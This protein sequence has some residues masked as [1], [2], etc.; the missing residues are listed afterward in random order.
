MR[1][2]LLAGV[3]VLAV[4]APPAEATFH[5]MKVREVHTGGASG[6]SYVEL[7]MWTGGQNE[8]G[9]HPIVVYAANGSPQHTFNLP[10]DVPNGQSQRTVLIAG[11][12]YA[13]TF[14]SGPSA[15]ATDSEL[16][17][18][19]A[20]G[21]VCFTQ[22]SPPDCV[23]WGSFT[24]NASLPAPGAGSPESPAGVTAGRAL[25]RSIAAGC[26][27]LL[28]PVDDTDDSAADFSEQTP[29]PRSN[30]SAI[31]ETVCPSLP[32]TTIT[33]PKPTNPTKS[34][35]ASFTFTAT[36]STGAT[37]ECKLDAEPE[38]TACSSP[39]GYTELSEATH[40]FEVRA[41]NS[42]GADPSPAKHE[43]RVDLTPPAATIL[44]QPADPSPGN[45]AS[46]TY[47]SDEPG[48]TFQ[49]S[50]EPVGESPTFASCPSSGKTYPDAQHP[51]PFADGEWTFEV[52]A[53]DLA[54]NQGGADAFTWEVDN[55]IADETPP[56]TKVESAPPDPSTSAT[57]S[58]TYSSTE[59]GS[60]FECALDGAAFA[61]CP[62]SGIVYGPLAD[63]PHSFQVRATDGAGNTDET[64]A[65]YS[66][67]VAVAEM[68][69][70]PLPAPLQIATRPQTT[71]TA[72]PRSTTRDRTPS[73][74]FRSNVTG[75]TFQCKVDRGALRACRSPFTTKP[76][77][78]GP[79][80]V[81]IRA[82]AA[83]LTDPTPAVARFKVVR[84]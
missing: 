84:L 53:T 2:S 43:W 16:N 60:S 61:S 25:H 24:G 44:T 14:P 34:T 55:S 3:V 31:V 35:S 15:D 63:G 1:V 17:L 7:Q 28:E 37:F 56:E 9:G 21:A 50:L 22:A 65:G 36:P 73:F 47:S 32:N 81:R 83:G 40:K 66:W 12:G 62:A 75:S 82:L 52:R 77:A 64:P 79:H 8:V 57:A 6:G 19:A 54:G 23:S 42:A 13:T 69:A 76:L 46:F 70:P 18:P 11:P 29:N 4:W 74:R 39:K 10:A 38:F 41:V 20:G 33:N 78:P 68:I 45:S 26:A 5:F 48:S 27:T 49:C 58:F 67:Q 80:T 59:I 51:A 71:I 72:K 30:G